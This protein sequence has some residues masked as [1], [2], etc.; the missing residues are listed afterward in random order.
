MRQR[1]AAA[2]STILL[3]AALAFGA[4]VPAA[5]AAPSQSYI[6]T[7]RTSVGTG[8]VAAQM[9]SRPGVQV[10]H[11]FN[12]AMRGFSAN[13]TPQALAT[14]RSD[15]HVVSITPNRT[16]HIDSVDA[17]PD[18]G[19]AARAPRAAPAP[20]ARR[21]TP[22]A[23]S[24]PTGISRIGGDQSSTKSGDGQGEV[25]V[26][27]AVIDTGVDSSHTDLNVNTAGGKS[28]VEGDD[29]PEDGHG[30]GTHVSGTIGAKDDA[31]GV[32]G[33]APGARIWPVRVLDANGSGTEDA[34][35][36]GIDHV[37]E[38]ASEID[39][40]NMSLGGPGADS[41]CGS[42][43]DPMHEAICRSVQAG[44]TYAVAAGNESSDASGSTP[45]AYDEVIT[46]SAL[47]D[48]DGKTGG[49]GGAPGCRAEESDDT[50]ATFSNFGEDVDIIAPGVC[51][52]STFK[53]GGFEEL[54]GT[55]M[56]TPH[57]AGAAALFKSANPD[58][59]PDQVKEALTSAGTDDWDNSGDQDGTKEP[60]LN[61]TTF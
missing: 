32:V 7:L 13:L 57:V 51:I 11:V 55:S 60:L 35:I 15:P 17:R 48:S 56:A 37:T 25:D 24:I 28:C 40:V 19:P 22:Q 54:S 16:F 27:V 12:H 52:N 39:V 2:G 53:G 41:A 1:L 47:S 8:S 20:A 45:A 38:H 10:R 29:S 18:V 46:V 50:I 36:C 5:T 21:V 26:D 9:Q 43:T 6:I 49:A 31:E 59:T 42:N 23:Q 44:V 30:H 4:Y 61:V 34:V 14:L 33:V 3:G 58:A